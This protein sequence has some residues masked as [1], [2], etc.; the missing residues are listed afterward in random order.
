[1]KEEKE[2][3]F[4][5][6]LKQETLKEKKLEKTVTGKI[7][8]ITSKGEI[9]VDINYK[10]DGIIP[11]KEYSN[12]ENANPKDE[13]KV[14]DTIT[15]D[16]LKLNDGLGNVLLSYKRVK[17]RENKNKIEE[18]YKNSE[19]IEAKVA[20]VSEKGLIVVVNDTQIFIPISLSG[21]S[22]GEDVNAYLDK[23]VKFKIT[24]Y[25]AKTNRIIGSIRIVLD[26]EKKAKQEEFWNSIELGKKYKGIVSSLSSYG[27]F[28]DLGVT[29][30]LLHVSEISW[31]RNAKV[32]EI[33]KQGQEIE[34]TVIDLDK[35]NR[36]IK[37]SYVGKGPN[38]WSKVSEKYHVG[39][40]VKVKVVKMMPFGVFV[41][42]EAG[43]QGLVHIS[44]IVERKITKPEEELKI[45]QNVNAKIIE[46]DVENQKI[47]L[48]IKELE[49]TSN[50]YKEEL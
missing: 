43:I 17:N 40:I 34:V 46:L 1:M 47:E 12:D 42:L 11:K 6:L 21:I 16:V 22:R 37:L 8:S 14:G 4:E 44:Q 33:L 2:L 28:V 31:D 32:D 9:F 49:G 26:E 36:R 30:G 3:T 18:K 10:A 20:K 15:A 35:E 23:N 24:E 45:G 5:E 19:I 48:S 27:A 50:E 39:D 38:P 13:F 7:I 41:E 25:D 29:Q